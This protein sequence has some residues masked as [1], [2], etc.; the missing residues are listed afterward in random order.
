MVKAP[1]ARKGGEIALVTNVYPAFPSD[2]FEPDLKVQVLYSNGTSGV[3][4][5]WQIESIVGGNT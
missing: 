2:A 1:S 3:W 5:D 4:F